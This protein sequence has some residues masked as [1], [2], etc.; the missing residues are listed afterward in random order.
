VDLVARRDG[1]I[2]FIEVK[3]RIRNERWRPEDSVTA[4]K[5]ERYGRLAAYFLREH[6]L[7]DTAVRYH[8]A[9]ITFDPDGSHTIEIIENAFQP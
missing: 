4:E 7:R 9:A 3:T 6:G 2:H 5:T 1:A 8:I